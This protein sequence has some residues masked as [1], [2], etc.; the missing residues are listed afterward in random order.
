MPKYKSR[1]IRCAEVCADLQEAAD[2]LQEFEKKAAS[3][4]LSNEEKIELLEEVENLVDDIHNDGESK[5]TCLQSEV[6]ACK[7]SLDNAVDSLREL[8][9]PSDLSEIEGMADTVVEAIQEAE[10]ADFPG[11]CD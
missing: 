3:G 7:Y 2:K 1:A 11:M 5:L 9:A 4:Q 10:G 8:S 6:E